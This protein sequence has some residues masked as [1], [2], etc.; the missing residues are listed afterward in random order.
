MESSV[1][2]AALPEDVLAVVISH[3]DRCAPIAA[4]ERL[5]KGMSNYSLLCIAIASTL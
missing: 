4:Y 3:L 2:V 1:G 5:A